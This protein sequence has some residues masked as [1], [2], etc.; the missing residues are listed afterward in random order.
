MRDLILSASVTVDGFMARPPGPAA[1]PAK[2]PD[3]GNPPSTP[4]RRKR[5]QRGM[6]GPVGDDPA[7]RQV[8]PLDRPVAQPRVRRVH[9]VGVGA[10]PVSPPVSLP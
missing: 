7:C 2:W 5:P 9:E 3:P 4:G 1:A 10:L 6:G 8:P